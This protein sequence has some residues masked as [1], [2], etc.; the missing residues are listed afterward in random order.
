MT[1]AVVYVY[2]VWEEA[3]LVMEFGALQLLLSFG[4]V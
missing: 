4:Y 2:E 3:V 1:C